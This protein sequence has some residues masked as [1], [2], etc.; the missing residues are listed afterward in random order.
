[1]GLSIASAHP[2][3]KRIL[4]IAIDGVSLEGLQKAKTPNIDAL[5]AEGCYS[6]STRNVMPTVTMPNWTSHLT[7]VGPEQHGVMDNS[8]KVESAVIPAQVSDGD[9]YFPSVFKVLKDRVPNIKTAFYWNW[10]NLINAF[11]TKY[12]DETNFATD[13]DFEINTQKALDFLDVNRNNPA[14]VFLYNVAVDHAGHKNAWMSSEYIQELEN[15]DKTIGTLIR[16]LKEK[17]LYDSTHIMFITDHGGVNKGH[18]GI[19]VTE[20]VIPWGIAGKGIKKGYR[21]TEPNNTYNTAAT[22]YELFK[23]KKPSYVIGTAPMFI[24]K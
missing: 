19:S 3:A 1:M 8:H 17:N 13:D 2:K 10:K 7:G 20:M 16:K 18:G 11:N 15:T 14:F 5:L 4:V 9:G 12:M 22:I 6:E 24:F 21:I 23:V